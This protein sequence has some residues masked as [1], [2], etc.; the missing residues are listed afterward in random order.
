MKRPE[1]ESILKRARL[2]EIS[3][4]SLEMFPRR[5]IAGLNREVP[6]PRG[7]PS[8][9]PRLAW[10][11]GLAACLLMAL[12]IGHRLT[13][14]DTAAIPSNDILASAKLVHEMQSMF[15]DRVRAIVEDAHGLNLVLSDDNNVSASQ[16]LYVHI[17]DGRNCA[18]FVTFSGQEIQVAG[19]KITTLSDAH[20]GIIVTGSQFVWS[21]GERFY[22]GNHMTIEAKTLGPAAM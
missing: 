21:S 8:L 9:F 17:C 13:R 7:A 20:G 16:P 3:R 6:P 15:P 4:D 5:V 12:A 1:L 22:A 11:G 19:Q 10:A 2:P 14:T 18:S